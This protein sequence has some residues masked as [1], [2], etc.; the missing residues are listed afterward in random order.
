MKPN[1]PVQKKF[2]IDS[3]TDVAFREVLLAKNI[4]MR[5]VM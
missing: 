5:S 4:S 1:K 2:R 3:N